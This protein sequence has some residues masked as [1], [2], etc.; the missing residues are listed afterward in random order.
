MTVIRNL[1]SFLFILSSFPISAQTNIGDFTSVNPVGQSAVFVIPSTHQFQYIIEEGEPIDVGGNLKGNNDFTG[2]VPIGGRSDLG[3]LSINHE[4]TPGGVTTLDI[5]L[6][7]LLLKWVVD[8]SE[9]VDF[10]SVNGTARNCSG[11]ITPWGTT[12][13]CEETITGDGNGDNYNDLGWAVELD[14]V[15][16]VV[17]NKIWAAG[18]FKHENAVIHSNERTMYQGADS[19]PGYMYKFVADNAQDLSSGKLYVYVGPKNGSGS[20]VLLNNSTPAERNS[21]LSQSNAVGATVFNGIEDCEIGPDGKI[22]FAVKGERKVYRFDDDN[23]ITGAGVSNF[24]TY[25]GDMNYDITHSGGT[26]STAWGSGND[27]LDFDGEGNLWVYQDGGRNYIWVVEN[28]HTQAAPLVK[29][30]GIAPSGSEPTGITFSPD[31]KYLFMSVQHPSAAN[32]ATGQA[33]AFGNDQFFDK[34]VSLVIAL[35]ENL[36]NDCPIAGTPCDDGQINTL[37]DEQ[38]GFCNCVG[39]VVNT[40]IE[41]CLKIDNPNDDVEQNGVDNSMYFTSTDLELVNDGGRG[42]QIVGVRFNNLDIP[43]GA[44]VTEAYLQFTVDEANSNACDLEISAELNPDAAVF[45]DNTN[46]LGLR[47]RTSSISWSPPNWTIVGER[48]NAQKSPDIKDM[49]QEVIDQSSF[50]KG[51]SIALFIEGS[52]ERTAESFEGDAANAPELCIKYKICH[53][54]LTLDA[55]IST[56]SGTYEALNSITL[57]GPLAVDNGLTLELKAPNIIFKNVV[58]ASMGNILVEKLGCQ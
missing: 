12:I 33:D 52:G 51:N 20:W 58:D 19:N 10:S 40:I 48:G 24:E 21:T 17:L 4:T 13:T 39:V 50:I 26:T 5:H 18:N 53:I 44:V 31:Y 42:D 1:L 16:K 45:Q 9:A 55:S 23:A 28:G 22:Y 25:V 47:P 14:P 56:L 34:S 2:Y 11:A 57:Q 54:D 41:T 32:S 29:L 30:F 6:D 8:Y 3:Y 36:G 49:V 37:Y 27:N 35:D 43:Q 15:N 46:A 38:D 7:T